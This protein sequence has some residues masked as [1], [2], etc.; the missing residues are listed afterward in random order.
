MMPA[1]ARRLTPPQS[2]WWIWNVSIWL[3]IGLFD[4]TKTVFVM[5]SEGMHHA[6]TA[7]FVTLLLSRL[8]WALATPMV[9]RLGRGDPPWR[10]TRVATWTAHGIACGAIALATAAWSAAFEKALNPWAYSSEAGLFVD[11]W[12]ARFYNGLLESI[13]LYAAILGTKYILDSRDRLLREEAEKARLNEQLAKAKLSALRRQ[14]EPHFLF[15]TLNSIAAQVR[16]ARNDSAVHML[17]ALS[18]VLRSVIADSNRQEVP[19][20]DELELLQKYLDIQKV[21]FGERL[22]VKLDVPKELSSAMVPPLILQP[23][24][25]N[26]LHHGIAKR[27]REGTVEISAAHV[28]GLLRLRVYDDGPALPQHG[29]EASSGVGLSNLR[30]RLRSLYGDAY[31][32]TIENHDVAGVEVLVSVPFREE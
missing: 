18:D 25:E 13:F 28:D 9:L 8:P 19:L 21:R 14:I 31:K 10:F 27:A 22:R 6:W 17:A 5:R 23:L 1:M 30:D 29:P 32:F 7:L 12:R 3:G 15:N 26:A 11:L 20:G 2:T 24:V 16:E 4:A